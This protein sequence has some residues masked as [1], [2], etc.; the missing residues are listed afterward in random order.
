MEFTCVGGEGGFDVRLNAR[1]S[2][3][4]SIGS[5]QVIDGW[6]NYEGVRASGI[7]T[8]TITEIGIDDRYTGV[9]R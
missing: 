8:G 7:L 9:A 1:F 2:D 6:G 3:L 5:W 4:G